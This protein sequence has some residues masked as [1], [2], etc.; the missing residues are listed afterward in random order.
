MPEPKTPLTEQDLHRR[1]LA[2][3]PQAPLDVVNHFFPRLVRRLRARFPALRDDPDL[4]GCALESLADYCEA[5]DRFDADQSSLEGWL[6][7]H[8]QRDA[9]NLY[10]RVQRSRGEP[11]EEEIVAEEADG[12]NTGRDWLDL[13]LGD[14]P[15][16]PPEVTLDELKARVRGAVKE[17]D[18]DV[19]GLILADDAS[20][21]N[22]IA[23]LHLEDEPPEVQ[24]PEVKRARDRVQAA[25]RRTRDQYAK[26]R[27]GIHD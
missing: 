12:R 20:H 11:L 18:R 27:G 4:Q 17:R 1:M 24:E 5:P 14:H 2:G 8:A 19:L 3:E 6:Q 21:E 7:Y 23:A 9:V 26:E 25:I 16:L 10:R 13:V 15:A 22:C